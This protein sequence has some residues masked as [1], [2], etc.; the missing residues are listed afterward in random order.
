MVGAPPI[1][2]SLMGSRDRN[3]VISQ[4]IAIVYY[5]FNRICNG[6]HTTINTVILLSD[7]HLVRQSFPPNSTFKIKK[8]YC[9]LLRS[10]A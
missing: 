10:R 1:Q 5:K 3:V 8:S 9:R 2:N 7:C 6:V 4:Q